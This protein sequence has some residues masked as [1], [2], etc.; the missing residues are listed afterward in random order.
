MKINT[1]NTNML[2]SVLQQQQKLSQQLAAGK[3]INS[4]A[5]DAAGLQIANRLS[6]EINA[7]QQGQRNLADGI[8]FARVYDQALQ[9]IND[10][11][12]ELER[13]TIAAGN[14]IY[15]AADKQA[16]QAEAN[17]YLANIQQGL[18]SEFAGRPLFT[19]AKLAFSAGAS[20]LNIQTQDLGSVLASQNIFNLDLTNSA[21]ANDTLSTIRNASEQLG[22][23]Q[24]EVGASIN[25]MQ[26][27]ANLA[28]G[29][30]AATAEARSRIADLDFAKASSERAA[31]N[32][33]TQSSIN[34]AMQARVSSE[35]ALSLLT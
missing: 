12:L 15:S 24:A 5:D 33:L 29:Q 22:A 21:T 3:R 4:A 35:Q 14:G 28:A 32:I 8:A 11:V 6:S 30:Q 10:N 34:V 25:A 2:N 16:L 27:A 20:S 18:N 19:D 9:G 31:N 13:L 7:Q 23:F 1:P 17:G 26:S